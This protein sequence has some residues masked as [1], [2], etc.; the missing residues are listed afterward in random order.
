MINYN[1]TEVF[2]LW[3]REKELIDR[4]SKRTIE[5]YQDA[6][7][8]FNRYGG[9]IDKVGVKTFVLNAVNAKLTPRTINSYASALNS[10]L[11]WLHDEGYIPE[12]LT[13][14]LQPVQK[15][16]LPTYT[17]EA[18]KRILNHKP[19]T[20]GEKR[21]ITI[22][23]LIADVGLRID[24]C[25]TLEK[26]A[27]DW[28][29]CLLTIKGKGSKVRIIPMS[30]DCRSILYKYA[31]QTNPDHPLLFCTR[32]GG[33]LSVHNLRRDLVSLLDWIGVTKEVGSFHTFRRLACKLM[34]RSGMDVATA[35]RILGHSAVSITMN[36]YL[37]DDP[38][39]LLSSHRQHS[40]LGQLKRS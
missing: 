17:V 25:L 6:F 35:S 19:R 29:N 10:H 40:P 27:I 18:A 8:A 22:L 23:N 20:K 2:N 26:S 12:R 37:E 28:T 38:I 5:S 4:C 36:H 14:P 7:K 11:H 9:S 33:K 15:K 39:A 24:E 13:I 16:V 34:V 1:P 30:L 32:S 31:Q 21:L 3:I